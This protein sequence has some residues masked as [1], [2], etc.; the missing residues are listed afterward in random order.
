MESVEAVLMAAP[1]VGREVRLPFELAVVTELEF[2][3]LRRE[4]TRFLKRWFIDDMRSAC[5]GERRLA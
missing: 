5:G 2:E 4:P 3:V 1:F